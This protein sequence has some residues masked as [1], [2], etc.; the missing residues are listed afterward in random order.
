[1]VKIEN[2]IQYQGILKRVEEL[3]D[4]LPDTTPADDPEMIEL[5]LLG[6]LVAEYDEIHYPVGEPSLIDEYDHNYSCFATPAEG[7][8]SLKFRRSS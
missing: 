5:I 1:M 2:E 6:N 8:L 7:L 3:M 4:K